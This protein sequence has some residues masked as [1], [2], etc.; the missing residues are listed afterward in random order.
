MKFLL[1]I[2]PALCFFIVYYSS[3][4]ENSIV[5]ATFAVLASSLIAFALN[6]A[7]FKSISRMQVIILV[8]LLLFAAPTIYFN[9]PSFIKWKVSIVNILMALGLGVCQFGFKT[10]IAKALT[11]IANPIP[12]ELWEKLTLATIV[13]LLICALLNYFLAFGLTEYFNVDAKKAD[14]IWV[15]YKTYGNGIL[16]FIF[17]M[18]AF[19]K[20]YEKLTPTQKQELETLL[21]L[22]KEKHLAKKNSNDDK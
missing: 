14:D 21:T 3:P 13:F 9:D 20:T 11:G 2:L 17:V 12:E 5:Y 8:L 1:N 7:L 19:N 15:N 6:Y 22:A 10:N 16:N 18:V 4:Q